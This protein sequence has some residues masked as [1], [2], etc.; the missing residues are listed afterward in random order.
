MRIDGHYDEA[1]DVAWLRFEGF[2]AKRVVS[3]E[4]E[5]GLREL[6]DGRVVGL[7]FWDARTRLP[8]ALLDALPAPPV[9]AA[10]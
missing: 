10:R 3:E 4:A 9:E 8:A 6:V 5:H 7:E 1:A 2:D